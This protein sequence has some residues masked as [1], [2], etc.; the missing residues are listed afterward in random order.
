MSDLENSIKGT[1]EKELEKG[2]IEKVI[3]KNLEKCIENSLSNMFDCEGEIK[4]VIEKKIKAVMIPYLEDYDYSKYILK[5]DS[6]LV[7]VLQ[8]T[9]LENKKIIENFKE[10]MGSEYIGEIKLSDIFKEWIKYCEEIVDK[11]D[12][13]IDCEGGY[14]NTSFYVQEVSNTWSTQPTYI[15]TFE[16]EEDESLKFE[17]SMQAEKRS[18]GSNYT[19]NYKRP[20]DLRTLRYLNKFELLLIRISE[21]REN[22][23]FD[24]RGGCE[25]T[26]VKYEGI[27]D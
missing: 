5:L 7:D 26:F 27:F 23:I 4:E 22:I 3:A 10:L 15:V 8:S 18:E 12:L 2:I 19:S 6:V 9:A 17:F 11:D 25:Q 1:I 16:C 20:C 21:G 14:I 24:K 13:D